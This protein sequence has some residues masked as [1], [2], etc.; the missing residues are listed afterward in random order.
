MAIKAAEYLFYATFQFYRPPFMVLRSRVVWYG[1]RERHARI[2]NEQ[3]ISELPAVFSDWLLPD[4]A[5]CY[6][7][8]NKDP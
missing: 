3:C 2:N 1:N 7:K 4:G 5:I 6:Q 8:P